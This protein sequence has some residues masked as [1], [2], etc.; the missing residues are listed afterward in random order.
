[1]FC[2]VAKMICY[3]KYTVPYRSYQFSILAFMGMSQT[4]TEAWKESRTWQRTMTSDLVLE[5]GT[6]VKRLQSLEGLE[7]VERSS[8]SQIPSLEDMPP[9]P[10]A[11]ESKSFGNP[12]EALPPLSHS[13]SPFLSALCVLCCPIPQSFVGKN[14][15]STI[16]R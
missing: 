12:G 14:T 1:M 11:L 6:F 9:Q 13:C 10:V 3:Q 7:K 4:P 15:T 2:Y 16:T 8:P 5:L